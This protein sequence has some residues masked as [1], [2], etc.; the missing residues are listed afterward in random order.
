MH[1]QNPQPIADTGQRIV[2][3][4]EQDGSAAAP[5]V[6]DAIGNFGLL[7]PADIADVAH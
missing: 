5:Y 3:L 1:V 2:E 6:K 4:V 7:A